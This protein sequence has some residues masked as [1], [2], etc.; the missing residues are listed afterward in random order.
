MLASKHRKWVLR[1][2]GTL[3]IERGVVLHVLS[4]GMLRED[5]EPS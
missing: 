2:N 4:L 1:R 5:A 3:P